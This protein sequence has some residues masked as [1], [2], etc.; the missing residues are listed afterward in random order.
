M[1]SIKW[2]Y[3]LPRVGPYL[4]RIKYKKAFS[5]KP[6]EV[7]LDFGANVGKITERMAKTGATV[8]A[9]EPDPNAFKE[10]ENKFKN[11]ANVICINKA[12]SDHNGKTKLYFNDRYKEDPIKW[13]VGTSLLEDKPHMDTSA[14]HE[15]EVVDVAQVLNDI[16][17]PIGLIK[18]DIEG[19]EI[20]VLNR[21]IDSNIVNRARNIVV[22]THERFPTLK[23]PTEELRQK[24][25]KLKLKNI[26][27]DWA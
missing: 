26:D 2:L 17:E 6:G 20:K 21:I 24:I 23:R 13:S 22:E 4:R 11:I 9:F 10:L 18:V 7:A 12:V 16:K 27:L 25:K 14:F 5:L 19:E 15:V 1:V 8:Y 3:D